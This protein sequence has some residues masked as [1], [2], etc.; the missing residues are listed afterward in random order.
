MQLLAAIKGAY[1]GA[2]AG[3][4]AAL[5]RDPTRTIMSRLPGLTGKQGA[6]T[7]WP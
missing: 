5:Y 7:T 2:L 1:D 4:R 3:F 6:P